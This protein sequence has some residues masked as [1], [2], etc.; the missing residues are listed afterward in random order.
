MGNLLREAFKR[1]EISVTHEMIE[2]QNND[3]VV[4]ALNEIFLELINEVNGNSKIKKSSDLYKDSKTLQLMNKLDYTIEERFGIPFKMVAMDGSYQFAVLINSPK[5]IEVLDNTMTSETLEQT[6]EVIEQYRLTEQNTKDKKDV[7]EVNM[8]GRLDQKDNLDL[9]Y[10]YRKSLLSLRDKLKTGSVFVDRKKGKIIGLPSELITYLEHDLVEFIK[11]IKLTAEELTGCI[12]HE[13]GHAFTFIEY[14]YRSVTNTSV[15]IDTFL[16]NI[17]KKN[18]SPKDALILAYEKVSGDTSSDYKTKDAATATIYMLDSFLKENRFILTGS[19]HSSV[20]AE[21]LADQFMGR[22]GVG[23]YVITALEKIHGYF[24]K[25]EGVNIFKSNIF[26]CFWLASCTVFTILMFMWGMGVLGVLSI[27]V[28]ITGV[29]GKLFINDLSVYDSDPGYTAT[30]DDLKR[31]YTR[32]RNEIV[33]RLRTS[34][35][36][37]KASVKSMIDSL[38]KVDAILKSVPDTKVSLI[39]SIIRKLSSSTKHRLEIRNIERMIE[40]L[41]ENNLYVAAAKIQNKL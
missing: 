9:I 8:F 12:L 16:E 29:Y 39:D 38:D 6:K 15:L 23:E 21:Q 14:A 32:I 18:R 17:D 33:R 34:E 40:D 2:Q 11:K 5:D 30:Y 22:F 19:A 37:S 20:D 36:A 35:T 28:I 41:S 10:N 24:D 1:E 13:I 7:N 26:F 25:K 3:Y 27:I 4:S 31:R